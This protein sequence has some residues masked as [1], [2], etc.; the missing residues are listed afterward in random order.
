MGQG[1]DAQFD[2]EGAWQFISQDGWSDAL[3]RQQ[4]DKHPLR[5]TEKGTIKFYWLKKKR[6]KRR[7]YCMW[8]KEIRTFK[9][10]YGWTGCGWV[11]P[12]QREEYINCM[13]GSFEQS[14]RPWWSKNSERVSNGQSLHWKGMNAALSSQWV[15]IECGRRTV[16]LYV[17][18]YQLSYNT[19]QLRH[20]ADYRS[21]HGF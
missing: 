18:F 20:I 17:C 4:A 6:S 3:T 15:A 7:N 9:R 11:F 16:S 13:R 5:R 14:A 19:S 21:H 1:H 10:A 8:D 2:G 12:V